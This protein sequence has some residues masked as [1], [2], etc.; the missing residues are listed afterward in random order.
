M[1]TVSSRYAVLIV[2]YNTASFVAKAVESVFR[3][4]TSHDFM[5]CVIDNA[6]AEPD[7]ALLRNTLPPKVRLT[8]LDRNGGFAV[9]YNAAARLAEE[10]FEPEF[11]VVMNPDIELVDRGSIES[12]IE[13]TKKEGVVGAQP[14]IHSYRIPGNAADQPAIRRVPDVLDLV[15]SESIVLRYVFRKRF[16]RFLM[17][18]AG[19]Y[20]R[21]TRFFVPSGAFFVI[22]AQDFFEVG[23]FDEGTFL[24]AEELILGNKLARRNR[25]FTFDPTVTVRHFQGAATGFERWKPNRRMYR[26]RRD[27]QMYYVREYTGAG[28][29]QQA[30]LYAA[31]EFGYL[32]RVV[33]WLIRRLS[34]LAGREGGGTGQPA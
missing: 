11:L 3:C 17:L 34:R 32:V 27:S 29:T 2:N 20:G 15:I 24:Y 4:A 21:S 7:R 33:V 10:T 9:G 19:S 16:K 22:R 18:D 26:F 13:C 12:L 28:R 5:V 25:Q 23:G 6:S 31:M 8:E 30:F 1:S 14:L